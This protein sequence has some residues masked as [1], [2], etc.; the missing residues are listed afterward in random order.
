[1]VAA[2]EVAGT[3]NANLEAKTRRE[4]LEAEAATLEAR[5]AELT[6]AMEGRTAAKAEA[7]ARAVMPVDGL[8]FT[9]EA[10]AESLFRHHLLGG[11]ESA[12]GIAG[13]CKSGGRGTVN[14]LLPARPSQCPD[15]A[16]VTE[17]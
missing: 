16:K 14:R 5:A 7:I 6:A 10:Y 4:T 15:A 1:L 12:A 9:K 3:A 8:G 13:D 11:I 17:C 2:I